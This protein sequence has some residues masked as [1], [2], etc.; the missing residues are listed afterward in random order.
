MVINRVFLLLTVVKMS[1]NIFNQINFN[2]FI[3]VAGVIDQNEANLILDCGVRFLGFPL[4]LPVNKV[5]LSEDTA[6]EI[7]RKIT[8][9]NFAIIIS[10]SS[11]AKEAV[12]LCN[13]LGSNI[14]QLHGEISLD[15]LQKIKFLQS[16]IL[17]I[18][19]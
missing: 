2:N 10:Y 11:T 15:E 1:N 7:I 14:I 3:Q 6:T 19:S 17:I 13:K 8:P 12:E 4:R 18:K 5:D 9:P 16:D